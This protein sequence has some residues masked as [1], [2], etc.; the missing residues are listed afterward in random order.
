MIHS[1]SIVKTLI[2][3]VAI[4]TTSTTNQLDNNVHSIFRQWDQISPVPIYRKLR[5]DNCEAASRT[6]DAGAVMVV[7]HSGLW[8]T[9]HVT[10][11]HV[12]RDTRRHVWVQRHLPGAGQ[13]QVRGPGRAAPAGEVHR[14]LPRGEQLHTYRY[15]GGPL[16]TSLVDKAWWGLMP[17]QQSIKLLVSRKFNENCKISRFLPFFEIH[18]Y[19]IRKVPLRLRVISQFSHHYKLEDAGNV[20]ELR[21]LRNVSNDPPT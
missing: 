2:L 10:S 11:W 21:N 6:L 13:L 7:R 8:Y 15:L 17:R 19:F 1:S 4:Y 18:F 14:D 5:A 20:K 12:T 9:W 3:S 16:Y